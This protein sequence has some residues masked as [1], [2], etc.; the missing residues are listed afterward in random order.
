MQSYYIHPDTLKPRLI[1]QVATVLQTDIVICPTSTGYRLIARVSAK[2][3]DKLKRLTQQDDPLTYP[4]LFT[5]LS[6]LSSYATLDNAQHRLIKNHTENPTAFILPATKAAPK[7]LLS[8]NKTL[9]A[10]FA[11][12]AIIK[13]LIEKMDQPLISYPLYDID[14][15]LTEPYLIQETF[16]KHVDGMIDVGTIDNIISTVLDLQEDI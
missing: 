7:I 12:G 15:T 2:S 14:D 8:K 13:A 3:F 9:C 4:I 6:Q 5:D 1:A 10:A 11:Q 16:G